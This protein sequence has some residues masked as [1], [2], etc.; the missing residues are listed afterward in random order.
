MSKDDA[1][2]LM[3]DVKSSDTDAYRKNPNKMFMRMKNRI[4]NYFEELG[5]NRESIAKVDRAT[6]Q[7]EIIRI[8]VDWYYAKYLYHHNEQFLDL[9]EFVINSSQNSEE[10][11]SLIKEYFSLPFVK[12]KSDETLYNEM[13]MKEIGNKVLAGLLK[14]TVANIERINSNRYSYKFDFLLFAA[15]LKHNG[16]FEQNRLERIQRYTN[17]AEH[18]YI[19]DYLPK[20]YV[21]CGAKGRLAIVNYIESSS[22]SFEIGLSKFLDKVYKSEPKDM[23]YYGFMARVLNDI[24]DIS[25]RNHYVR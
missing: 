2:N 9:Y 8:Y 6:S 17:S 22:N 20:L 19:A 7:E 21:Q 3:I 18:K 23:I 12:L 4:R 24:F 11:T 16:I 5:S 10:V 14:S 15:S 13:N 1:V 25:R